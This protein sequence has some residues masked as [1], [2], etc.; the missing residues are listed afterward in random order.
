MYSEHTQRDH[1][2]PRAATAVD[3]SNPLAP[4]RLIA[5]DIIVGRRRVRQRV[6]VAAGLCLGLATLLSTLG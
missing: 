3:R 4:R 5:Q 2:S 1:A 6:A